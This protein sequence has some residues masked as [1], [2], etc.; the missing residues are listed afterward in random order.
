LP[1][2]IFYDA[3]EESSKITGMVKNTLY[4]L[5][6]CAEQFALVVNT[7][8]HFTQNY[9]ELKNRIGILKAIAVGAFKTGFVRRSNY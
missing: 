4:L 1:K 2:G 3:V 9:S 7:P 6:L 8:V 5:T